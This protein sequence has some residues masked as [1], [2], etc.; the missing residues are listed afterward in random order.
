M[1]DEL[2]VGSIVYLGDTVY[3]GEGKLSP[4]PLEYAPKGTLKEL[5]AA[6]ARIEELEGL[7][8]QRAVD[9]GRPV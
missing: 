2:K 9:P 3:A 4:N 1:N 6:R 7:A 5:I 8:R